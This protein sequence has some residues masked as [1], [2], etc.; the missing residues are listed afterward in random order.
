MNTLMHSSLQV[1]V[2]KT[3]R[4]F[5]HLLRPPL[6]L[7]VEYAE[8]Q[9][10]VAFDQLY[11]DRLIAPH[12]QTSQGLQR[13]RLEAVEVCRGDA[14]TADRMTGVAE[15]LLRLGLDEM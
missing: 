8:A 2:N 1:I 12:G 9:P 7:I 3:N 11:S 10:L 4:S 5:S 13:P 6:Y 14:G 15:C